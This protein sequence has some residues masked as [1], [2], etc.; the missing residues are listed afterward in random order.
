MS[1]TLLGEKQ[2]K[3]SATGKVEKAFG[4]LLQVKFTG[5]IRQGEV[6]YVKV[7]DKKLKAE[8]SEIAGDLA[9]LQVFEDTRGVNFNTE[10]ELT[11][12][13]LEAELGPGL[14]T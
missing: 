6:A 1:E 2:V 14:L 3:V 5:S 12:D 7:G 13:L 8:V 4:N 9:K 10:V 11:G